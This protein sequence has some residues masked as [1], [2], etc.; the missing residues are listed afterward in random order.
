MPRYAVHF[1]GGA[2]TWETVEADSP[3]EAIEKAAPY[4]RLCHQ[5]S[6]DG[7]IGDEWDPYTVYD[8]TTGE[9]VWEEKS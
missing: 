2:S 9:L 3:E 4:W 7:D 6:S 8:D 1:T 5:C